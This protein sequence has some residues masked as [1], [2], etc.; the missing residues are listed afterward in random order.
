M[1]VCRMLPGS[2]D[3][4]IAPIEQAIR[5][6]PRDS[7]IGI[8]YQ[9]IGQVYLLQSR[10]DEAINW[11]EKSRTANPG[12]PISRALLASAYGLKGESERA[13]AELGEARR[14]S[15]DDRYSSI[16]HLQASGYFGVP[17]V[18]ELHE[19]TYFAGL[20]K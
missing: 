2:L 20:R 19:R 4:A 17:K 10:L 13:T 9:Q 7:Y 12:R 3:E 14:L 11:L 16:A 8:W 18:R 15:S 6:S 1:C 5:L